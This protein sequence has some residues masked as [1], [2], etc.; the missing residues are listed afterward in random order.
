MPGSVAEVFLFLHIHRRCA[1]THLA[2]GT[3]F[4]FG[5]YQRLTVLEHQVDFPM[6]C[7]ETTAEKAHSF[8]FQEAFCP[9]FAKQPDRGNVH[10]KFLMKERR[11]AGQGPNSFKAAICWAVP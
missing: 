6:G 8:L 11:W 9:P 1:L 10:T 4:D 2:G 3:V 5:K 7:F